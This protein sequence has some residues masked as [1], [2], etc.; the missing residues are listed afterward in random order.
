M[1]I[2]LIARS[3]IATGES[4]K[5]SRVVG[6]LIP[7]NLCDIERPVYLPRAIMIVLLLFL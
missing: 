5:I 6:I 7:T 4:R 2:E 3:D 1:M